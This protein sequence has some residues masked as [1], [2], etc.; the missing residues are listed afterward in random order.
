MKEKKKAR[1]CEILEVQNYLQEKGSR[2]NIVIANIPKK[3][4]DT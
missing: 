4:R 1:S 2:E 3:S